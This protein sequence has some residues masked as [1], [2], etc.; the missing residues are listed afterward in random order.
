MGNILQCSLLSS[1]LFHSWSLW[2]GGTTVICLD[3]LH[4]V[5]TFDPL[6]IDIS[7]EVRWQIVEKD[8]TYLIFM[9]Y[10]LC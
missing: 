6:A 4:N 3:Q 10:V 7:K 5:P 8:P 2:Q 1:P 9:Y